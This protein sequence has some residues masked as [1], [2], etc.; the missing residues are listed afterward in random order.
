M[1]RALAYLHGLLIAHRD[2]KADNIL[3]REFLPP[4]FVLSDFSIAHF[5]TT[6]NQF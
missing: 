5:Y 6:Q 3:V 1:L 2:I 4:S